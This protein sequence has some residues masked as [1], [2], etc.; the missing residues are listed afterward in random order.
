M[1]F[2]MVLNMTACIS[3]VLTYFQLNALDYR[4]WWR[5]FFYGGSSG[6]FVLLYS[7]YF[8]SQKTEM[9]G[10]LQVSYYFGYTILFSFAIFL[11]MGS[12]GFL[13]SMAFVKHIYERSKID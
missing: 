4:W 12:V 6:F 8:Y 11:M 7:I 9:F 3:I 13:A 2:V 5:S 1:V 10:F